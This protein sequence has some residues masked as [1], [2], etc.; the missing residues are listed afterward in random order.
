[1]ADYVPGGSPLSTAL[2]SLGVAPQTPAR[3]RDPKAEFD[4]ISRRTGVPANVL[5]ALDEAEGGSADLDRATRNAAFLGERISGGAKIEDAVAELAGDRERGATLMNRSYDI[6]DAMYPAPASTE[7][8]DRGPGIGTDV[9]DFAK[10]FGAGAINMTGG[11]VH[12]LGAIADDGIRQFAR[13]ES[14]ASGVQSRAADGESILRGGARDAADAV[15]G[16]GDRVRRSISERGQ[17]AMQGFQPDGELLSPSSWTLGDDPSVRGAILNTAQGLGSMAPL[18][19]MPGPASAA[20]F[21]A[22]GAAGEGAQEG[23]DFVERARGFDAEFGPAYIEAMPGYQDLRNQGLSHDDAADELTRRAE[24]EAGVRQGVPG[25]LGGAA[26][27]RIM[28]GAD[29]FLNAGSRAGRVAKK[30]V[31][32]AIEEGSQEALEGIAA[33]SG[34][35]DATGVNVNTQQGSFGNFVLGALSG[36]GMGAAS[37]LVSPGETERQASDMPQAEGTDEGSPDIPLLPAPESGGTIFGRSASQQ[38]PGSFDR[39]PTNPNRSGADQTGAGAQFRPVEPMPIPPAP[40]SVAS[41]IPVQPDTLDL[42]GDTPIPPEI[43]GEFTEVGSGGGVPSLLG[44]PNSDPSDTGPVGSGSGA[45]VAPGGVGAS[46]PALPGATAT[47]LLPPPAGPV[48]Q[49]ARSIAAA[50]PAPA[51]EV[52]P[53]FPDQKPGGAIRLGD[54]NSG[55]IVDGVFMGESPEGNARVRVQGQVVDLTPAEFDAGRDAVA[56]IEADRAQAEK[57]GARG[58]ADNGSSQESGDRMGRAIRTDD[59][60]PSGGEA[61]AQGRGDFP[62]GSAP[63]QGVDQGGVP[64]AAGRQQAGLDSL[65][66]LDVAAGGSD[67][68]GELTGA[69]AGIDDSAP[70]VRD[71]QTS[72]STA[73][74]NQAPQNWPWR[75]KKMNRA[76]RPKATADYL[77]PGNIIQGYGGEHQRVTA[78]DPATG[79]VSI[80]VV[81]RRGDEWAPTGEAR[82]HGTMPEDRA[83]MR[84]PVERAPSQIDVAAAEAHPEPTEAQKEAGN[85]RKGHTRWNGLDL[86]IENAKGSERRGTDPNGQEWSVTM[87]AHYGYFKRSEGADG[88]HVDFYMGD[89]P[90]AAHAYV[91]DQVDAETGAYDEAKV[92]LGFDTLD[93]ARGAHEAAFSDGRGA[94]RLGGVKKMPVDQLKDWLAN[95]DTKSPVSPTVRRQMPEAK[96]KKRPFISYVAEK[97]GGIRPGGALAGDLNHRG[98]TTRT[99]P[100]LFKRGGHKDLDN[101]PAVDH[102]ELIGSIPTVGETGYFDP[103]AILEAIVDEVAGRPL[104]F[105]EHAIDQQAA[106]QERRDQRDARAGARDESSSPD[107][108]D[109]N[110]DMRTDDERAQDLERDV[111][112]EIERLGLNGSLTQEDR[113]AIIAMADLHDIAASD[114]IHDYFV[115]RE[116]HGTSEGSGDGSANGEI[117][118]IPFGDEGEAGRSEPDGGSANGTGA[119]GEDLRGA[120][121]VDGDGDNPGAQSESLTE[122]TEEA[123]AE[124]LPQQIIPGAER[125]A[126][127]ARQSESDRAQQEMRARQQQ[128]KI[129]RPGGNDG[130]AGPLFDDEGGD[131]FDSPRTPA[132]KATAESGGTTLEALDQQAARE[133]PLAA[134]EEQAAALPS[135]LPQEKAERKEKIE[136]FGEKL[137]GARKD[138]AVSRGPSGRSG[139]TAKSDQPAWRRQYSVNQ[140][141]KSTNPAHEGKW[142]ISG[143]DGRQ[144]RAGYQP[145]LFDTEGQAEVAIPMYE[146]AK[147]HRVYKENDGTFA[148]YRR[149]TDRKRVEMAKGFKTQDEANL[150]MAQN[151]VKLIETNTRIDDSI[152]PALEQAIRLGETRRANDGDVGPRDFAD[153]FG[154]RGVEFGEWNNASE[155]QL[156]LNQA[157]DALLDFAE[158]LKVPPLALSLNGELG[159]AFGARGHGL[160]GARAH[161]ERNY[162]VINLTKIQGA[163]SLA[164][165]WWH[166]FDH[167]LGRQDGKASSKKIQN[168][169]GDTVWDAADQS[170]D[171]ASH[172]FLYRN[173]QVRPE[174]REAMKQVV[175]T[176][177]KR[178]A[179]YTE[180]ISTREVIADRTVKALDQKLDQFREALTRPQSWGRKKA[181]ATAEQL[182]EIDK[183]IARIRKGDL[184]EL[185]FADGQSRQIAPFQFYEPVM[186]I[187]KVYKAVR[188]RQGFGRTQSRRTGEVWDIQQAIENKLRSDAVLADAKEQRV[189]E[190]TVSTEFYSEAWILDQGR[191]GDYWITNHE[192]TARA[193][194]AYVYDRLKA[195]DARNDFLA[196]EKHNNLPEYRAFNVK[197]YPE[198]NERD[199]INEAFAKLFDTMQNR[200]TVVEGEGGSRPGVELY[201]RP[202]LGARRDRSPA[203]AAAARYQEAWNDVNARLR[204]AQR[205]AEGNEAGSPNRTAANH[206]IAALEGEMLALEE[207]MQRGSEAPPAT[208]RDIASDVSDIMRAH[209]LEGRVSAR[210]VNGLLSASGA[211]VLGSYRAG[212]INVNARAADPGHVLR[213]EVIHALRDATLWGKDYGLFAPSEWKALVRAARDNEVL[214]KA[215]ERAYPDLST[216]AQTEEM[217]AEMYADWATARSATP[218]GA[219]GRAFERIQSFFRAMASA[220]R[221][222]GFLDAAA[223]MRDIAS[224]QIGGR[225]PEGGTFDPKDNRISYQRGMATATIDQVIAAAR[226]PGHAPEKAEIGRAAAWVIE[227]A[228]GEGIDLS[229]VQHVIDGS[230][231]RHILK[232]HSNDKIERARGQAAVTDQDLLQ[233]GDVIA[234]PDAIATGHRTKIG[235]A[236][237]I[238]AKVMDDG[239]TMLVEEIRNNRN[240]AA[241]QT[242]WKMRSA[243]KDD[244]ALTRIL[245]SNARSDGGTIPKVFTRDSFVKE[246]RDLSALK[247]QMSR[248]GARAKGMIGNLHW[249]RTPAAVSKLWSNMLTDAMGRFEAANVLALVPGRPLF[250]EL[251]KNLAAAQEYLG[252]KERMDAERNEWQ[253]LSAS[254][255]DRWTAAARK[256]PEANE[257]LMEL[258]HDTTIAQIDPS[259]RDGWRHE[260]DYEAQEVLSSYAASKER[261]D[262]ARGVLEDQKA[263]E[264]DYPAL[265]ARFDRLPKELREIYE[266]I[267]DSYSKLADAEEAA[268]IEN[269]REGIKAT[270]AQARREARRERQRIADEMAEGSKERN[271]AMGKVNEKLA[272]AEARAARTSGPWLKQLRQTFESNRIS[273][274]YFPLSRQGHYFAAVRDSEG[275]LIEFQRFE[276]EAEQQKFATDARKESPNYRVKTGVIDNS[277]Q[278]KEASDP[279]FVADLEKTL[280]DIG[281]SNEAMDA[282]W[283]RY[284]QTMPGQ[285]MRKNRIHRKGTRGYNKDAMRAFASGMFHGAHQVARLRFGTQMAE[286]LAVAKE[287]AAEQPDANRAGF[288]VREMEKRHAFAMNPTNNPLVT[289]ATSAAFVWYLAASPAA[290]LVNVSQT[291]VVGVPLMRAH[292]KKA[293]TS[294]VIK[295]LTKA[296]HDFLKG[297]GK[298]TK[299]VGGLPVMSETWSVENAPDLTAD[300]RKAMQEGYERGVIDKTQAHDLAAV[301]ESGVQYNPTRE[302]VMRI[303]GWGFH[304]TERFNREVTYLAAYRLARAEGMDHDSATRDAGRVTWNVHFDYSNT[305][306][307]RAMQGDAAKV[308]LIFR[309]FSVNML[310]RLFRD[311]H[312]ALNGADAETRAEARAQLIGVS[313]SMFAHAGIRGVWGYGLVMTLLGLFFPGGGDDADEWLQDALLIEG[314]GAGPAAWNWMMGLA[315]NGV[316]GHATGMN[317]TERIG[318]PNLWFRGSDRDLEGQDLWAHYM[319]E[320]AGPLFSIPGNMLIGAG[321]V[322]EGHTLRGLEKMTPVFMRNPIKTVRYTT[323]GVTT[324]NGDELTDGLNPWQVF[325]QANGFTP[326][327]VAERYKIN[328]RLKNRERRI[329]DRR[330]DIMREIGDAARA[331]KPI[332]EGAIDK[333]RAFN[334]DF[335]V[336]PIYFDDIKQSMK[337][338]QRAR[339]RNEHGVALNPKLNN[340]LRGDLAP[341]HYN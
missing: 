204:A 189:K 121:R 102:P 123:G 31:A 290:A 40:E 152:H 302:K 289:T 166:A 159:L 324:V 219:L 56:Q 314:D 337:S 279:R 92:M 258:M 307:P 285:S 90:D 45:V 74:K 72:L 19:A 257:R 269:I 43:E 108:F 191:A 177:F 292:Y 33:K 242:M 318:M 278:A 335:P 340:T 134:G 80:E 175:Q 115:Q 93:A 161:Y 284:L 225:G 124:G 218:P 230:A 221:G 46:S 188:G 28:R 127:Q 183:A 299:R 214:R 78:Y 68:V 4:S 186:D 9:A 18:V 67:N 200:E 334:R 260:V 22:L 248:S 150:F 77:T 320:L 6:A 61:A 308:F 147:K 274:P 86:T 327:E 296:S 184:G 105:G 160:S 182:A 288:V 287:Q 57:E 125:S 29:R 167:Y 100:G 309:N 174:V 238:Y 315:L 15:R 305:S 178:R 306:R 76:T 226:K 39:D 85:Y 64:A 259:K 139:G 199:T 89:N 138:T 132:A 304:H 231:V 41:G 185:Q 193:F 181:A 120:G 122:P 331:G 117:S 97:F 106:R 5:I 149:V 70:S 36:A 205:R 83:L 236:A 313:L 7:R 180:D 170:K 330:R 328:T 325:V 142:A 322:M 140:I 103:E 49:A 8:P 195:V 82:T 252:L 197:P 249:K 26:T 95:G 10:S 212:Q 59:G 250:T 237:V 240:E 301:A 220:L 130:D 266:E 173:S 295:E 245:L 255:V 98:V 54:P 107:P 137:G 34:I 235:R 265:K 11:A 286:A 21:G 113:A 128:S 164:H 50:T 298:V 37:G 169:R 229:S 109:P 297:R 264:A 310:Y 73:G 251:G 119:P 88:D 163:G 58:N 179:E 2:Q 261:Q 114:A 27:N 32:G 42:A 60:L 84:G 246:Q 168:E 126:D 118:G 99:A 116:S 239:T 263:R 277:D 110:L 321:Q 312:Q 75:G 273:G 294:G 198:G 104:P 20:A 79:S 158:I 207:A 187:I 267:R 281:A 171:Y 234:N 87:P 30:G 319:G 153:V 316:P 48:E 326:A 96:Q 282:V 35:A 1:M 136:D 216:A 141:V 206:E 24:S 133:T 215:V 303:L 256:H 112:E 241:V 47:N 311:T 52:A 38:E 341:A 129:R 272:A 243:A 148:I 336:W 25:A 111:D 323:E 143:K 65:V 194:E 233:A 211:P 14:D 157:Y 176:A 253:A 23:R 332:P 202:A 201:S 203:P 244:N 3:A 254:T 192:M 291:T 44:I 91:I 172:G 154:F 155:R 209:G 66:G 222:E 300:E 339:D 145:M 213:H 208:A 210:V 12:A 16:V 329:T 156:I 283:Q 53:S 293:G 276:T 223:I 190:K 55:Q 94:A 227:A 270:L 146:V 217:V 228:A 162:G 271:E 280:A 63:V 13:A 101:I 232:N 268:V 165:E 333:M 71:R 338:R 51:P 62:Q 262:W 69:D 81:E 144:I 131:L 317:L 275:N 247:A 196:Y 224:G 151:A 135:L 17:Q